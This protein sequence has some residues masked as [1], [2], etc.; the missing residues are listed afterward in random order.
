MTL[1][2]IS[3]AP[4]KI[5]KPETLHKGKPAH[6]L[7]VDDEPEIA[8]SLAEYLAKKEGF[9]ISLAN[10]GQKAIDVLGSTV[11]V[12]EEI[13]LVLLDMRMPN[14]SGLEVL[15][16]I[17]KH[18]DLQYTR[19]VL[20]TAAAGSQEKVE[21]LSA[22]AD[23]YVTKP[24]SPQELLARVKTILRTLALEKQLQRQSQQ[25][26]ALNEIGQQVAA[27]LEQ[28]E[29][30]ATAVSG[31]DS[32]LDT[33][34]AAALILEGGKLRYKAV[35]PTQHN[36]D[37]T[38]YPIVNAG[39]GILGTV[40]T[41]LKATIVNQIVNQL[42]EDGRFSPNTDIPWQQPIHNM[43]VAPLIVR[44]RP[45]GVLAA[46]NKRSDN[47]SDFDLD[48][49][50][51]LTSS[52]SEAIENSWLFQ[53]IRQRQQE[54]LENRN[55]L[56]ALINGIPHP[57]YTINNNW[58][59]VTVNQSKADELNTTPDNL[60]GPLCYKAFFN[61]ES[62]CEHC[63][64]ALTLE[65]RQA[66]VWTNSWVEADHL[67]R[68]WDVSAYP[69]PSKQTDSARAVILWQDR[70]EE[71]RLESSLLQAGKLA[72]IGQ[73]A[74]GVAHEI[75]NPLTAVNGNAQILKLMIPPE[76]ENYESVDLISR[77]GEQA[78]R[79]VR[80]LLDFARQEQYAFQ[81]SDI[82]NSIQKALDLVQYQLYQA[83]SKLILNMDYN[84][85]KIVASWEHMKS[86]W[87]NLIVN[88]RDA[89]EHRP[90]NREV[91]ITTRMGTDKD[92]VQ[93]LIRDNGKGMT[94]AEQAH[95]FEPF[96]TT[97]D[98]GKG[99]GLGL[100]TC[101]RIIEQH[102][103]EINVVS[104]PGDGTTFIIRLPVENSS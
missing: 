69:I 66:K 38:E 57:I 21:A 3:T 94:K 43:I 55:T 14:M 102:G 19:V 77:A 40:L 96:Y 23:D 76:D 4:K 22:G 42:E 51:S 98:P 84:L 81:P 67:P 7:I 101:H 88:A 50:A 75:N 32:L 41:E 92:H 12:E 52:I 87:L 78:A 93:V 8:E 65:T 91:E 68:E 6:L 24:Y 53:K 29:V 70:T 103:G 85:P 61:R 25:L 104:A 71:R 34:L 58:E 36:P 28:S 99:T 13:H 48:L 11:G 37:A 97:K 95:I 17:R 1:T 100:A 18:P 26:A 16:W 49:F 47:F 44:G 63:G 60:V 89:V 5:P 54:L 73:L 39:Q 82:N 62:P 31:I 79:V 86:V 27:K 56:Q 46:Y 33:E 72:A 90:D 83:N 59:L 20:L 64:V 80:G 30:L 10:D 35:H 45:V 15:N 9:T 2:R 74:A